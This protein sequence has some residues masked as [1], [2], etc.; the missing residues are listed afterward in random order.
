MTFRL[1]LTFA[2]HV[3][4]LD[5]IS[6][7]L[8]QFTYVCVFRLIMYAVVLN[9]NNVLTLQFIAAVVVVAMCMC[10]CACITLFLAF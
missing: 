2:V 9:V 6:V 1:N 5:V 10:M 4:E 8:G 7:L 3:L